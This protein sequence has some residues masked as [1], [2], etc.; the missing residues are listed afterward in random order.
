MD[1]EAKR[2][3]AWCELVSGV[4]RSSGEV[5]L[6]AAG[7]SMLPTVWP[8]DVV[9]VRRCDFSELRLGQIVLHGQQ[10]NLTLH[11]I[12][13][14]AGDGLITRGDA[15]AA[16]DPPVQ[17]GEV[18]G[19]V[20]SIWRAGRIVPPEQRFWQRVGAAVFRRSRFLRRVTVYLSRRLRRSSERQTPGTSS[21]PLPA[22]K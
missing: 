14:I 19:R 18:I 1:I 16:F 17:A 12:V 15:L 8:G 20:V 7:A 2:R 10:Q 5:R 13:G 3:A 11:R 22:G 9:T 4:A 6:R 21:S